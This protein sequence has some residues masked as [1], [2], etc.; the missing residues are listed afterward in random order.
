MIDRGCIAQ[1]GRAAEYV[2]RLICL[3]S[4]LGVNAGCSETGDFGRRRPGLFEGKGGPDFA[5]QRIESHASWTDDETE[6][7]NRSIALLYNPQNP[8]F[9]TL[10]AVEAVRGTDPDLYYERVAG[11]ADQSVTARYRRV[12]LDIADDL[13]LIE[14]FRTVACKVERADRVRAVALD[15][16]SQVSAGDI[17]AARGRIAENSALVEKVE[18]ILPK[19]A[20]VYHAALE[21][22][23]AASP[24]RAAIALERDIA[25]LRGLIAARHPCDGEAGTPRKPAIHK[26]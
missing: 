8:R 26:G 13:S 1:S 23:V 6:L 5:P 16:E 3:A 18:E 24:D 9:P 4:L 12:A 17:A 10:D 21:H 20:D 11:R 14:P 15:A 25:S 7:R 2:L 22:L 19:R